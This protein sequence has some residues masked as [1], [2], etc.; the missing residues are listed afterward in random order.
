MTS[1][2][3]TVGVSRSRQRAAG[4]RGGQNRGLPHPQVENVSDRKI[5][6]TEERRKEGWMWEAKK[7]VR[8]EDRD[9]AG[10]RRKNLFILISFSIES[11]PT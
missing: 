5:R 4:Q 6:K 3:E 10:C 1:K 2:G 7:S 9:G 11:P 8:T